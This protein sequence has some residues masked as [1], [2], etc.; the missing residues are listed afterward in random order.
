MTIA[1]DAVSLIEATTIA[2]WAGLSGCYEGQAA[3]RSSLLIV[4][5]S[6]LAPGNATT[7]SKP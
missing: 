7:T 3:E 1:S 5:T 2:G 4:S 6:H